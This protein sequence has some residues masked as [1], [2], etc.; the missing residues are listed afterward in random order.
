MTMYVCK[1]EFQKYS[2]HFFGSY[3]YLICA[4]KYSAEGGYIFGK[5]EWVNGY[6]KEI[7]GE[8][9]DYNSIYPDYVSMAL[10]TRWSDGK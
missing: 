2:K 9:I 8:N 6:A 4:T 10:L 3:M 7:S 5:I 1:Q